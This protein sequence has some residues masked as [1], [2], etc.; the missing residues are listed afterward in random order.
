MPFLEHL[1]ELRWRIVK[2]LAA[3]A[4][5][6]FI[7]FYVVYAFRNEALAFVIRP[8]LPLLPNGKL[9]FTNIFEPFSILMQVSGVL[10]LVLASPVVGYQVWSFLVPALTERERGVIVPVLAFAAVLFLLGVAL[11]LFVFVPVTA[12]L[13]VEVQ[14][15]ALAP[16]ITAGDYLGTMLF[17]CLAFGALFELPILVL[18]LTAL[19]LI[20]PKVLN[21]ARR[22]AI[23]ISLVVCEIVTPGDAVIST[24]ILWVPVYGLYE[25]SIVVSW[26]VHRARLKREAEAQSIGAGASA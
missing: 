26:I 20:T 8:I 19:G 18:V 17:L 5:S 22:W 16:L 7:A 23:V 13:M 9:Y 14:S 6:F 2:S 4:I 25:L 3:L 12:K 24:L 10:A 21:K 15:E 1:E 11:A